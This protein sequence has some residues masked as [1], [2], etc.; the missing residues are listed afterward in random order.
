MKNL[1]LVT[2]GLAI[3]FSTILIPALSGLNSQ[4]NPNEILSITVEEATW[5]GT[6]E[7]FLFY[8]IYPFIMT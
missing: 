5:I 7:T 1:I 4:L 6:F 3:H 8:K 2:F